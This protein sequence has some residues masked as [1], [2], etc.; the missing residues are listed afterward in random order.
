MVVTVPSVHPELERWGFRCGSDAD[1]HGFLPRSVPAR[2]APPNGRQGAERRSTAPRAPS[3]GQDPAGER[4]VPRRRGPCSGAARHHR[5]DTRTADG[6]PGIGPG[7]GSGRPSRSAPGYSYGSPPAS[8]TVRASSSPARHAR[9]RSPPGRP[10][11]HPQLDA[12]VLEQRRHARVLAPVKRPLV[13]SGNNRVPAP[14][15]V[16]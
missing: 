7:P 8:M 4:A 1:G 15:H 9:T 10:L 16:R 2:S 11:R 13:L 12:V 5:G 3:P 14:A 6:R